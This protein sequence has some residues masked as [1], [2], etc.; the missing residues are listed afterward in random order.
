MLCHD[1]LLMIKINLIMQE[2]WKVQSGKKKSN[3]FPKE[4]VE[5]LTLGYFPKLLVKT[6]PAAGLTLWGRSELYGPLWV[7]TYPNYKRYRQREAR[8]V[9][10]Q[11]LIHGS[12]NSQPPD[13]SPANTKSVQSKNP[14]H[15]SIL[16]FLLNEDRSDKLVPCETALLFDVRD[17]FWYPWI[18]DSYS[19]FIAIAILTQPKLQG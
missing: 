4:C 8:Q 19:A 1:Y 16:P 9:R 15:Y 18:R 10:T 17:V 6:S 11:R 13:S 12:G 3:N 14:L 2:L 5:Q 7:K